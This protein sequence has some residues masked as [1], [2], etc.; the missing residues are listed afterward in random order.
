MKAP[1]Q[2]LTFVQVHLS[3]SYFQECV[4]SKYIYVT[5]S[6]GMLRSFYIIITAE[7]D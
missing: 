4:Y 1:I 5:L 2:F 3:K 7:Q 6:M